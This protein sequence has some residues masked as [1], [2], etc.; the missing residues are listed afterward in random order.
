MTTTT[1]GRLVAAAL[2][3]MV[4]GCDAFTTTTTTTTSHRRHETALGMGLDLVT[5]LRTEFISAALVTNQT[6]RAAD[7]CL[8]LGTDDG[9]AITFVPRTIRTFITSTSEGELTVTARRQLRQQ[10]ERRGTDVEIVYRDQA[11]DDLR[12]T[13]DDS[14]DVV[15][16]LQ[17]ADTMRERGLDWKGSVREAARVLRPGGRLLFVEMTELGAERK[18]Y[19]DYVKNLG[20]RV[21]GGE[22][23]D[24]DDDNDKQEVYPVFS[25]VSLDDVDLVLVPHVAGI[26]IKA[27]DAGLSQKERMQKQKKEEQDKYAELSISA[28][29]RGSKRKRKKK[30]KQEVAAEDAPSN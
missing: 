10:A 7:V 8:Q 27:V 1:I 25:E 4:G 16:S 23:D 22:G 13:A 11:S 20:V 2:L 28:F 9:R 26:A 17:A 14:V 29:E 3:T 18:S 21:G 24:N 5:Y 19:A 12:D 6:P 15:I 30:K